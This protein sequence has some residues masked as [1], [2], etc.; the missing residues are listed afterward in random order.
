PPYASKDHRQAHCERQ[1]AEGWQAR[2]YGHARSVARFSRHRVTETDH[3]SYS[4]RVRTGPDDKR[5]QRRVTLGH[6]RERDEHPV[7]SLAQARQAARDVKQAAAEGKALVPGDGLK[8]AQTWR[9][10]SEEY[11]TWVAG[12]RR[13]STAAEI[14]RILHS[15]DL[16]AWQD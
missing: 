10:L 15:R 9:E 12:E 4:V 1:A 11:I 7:L 2:A 13:P 16:A 6:P 3:R 14:K 8:G 5:V